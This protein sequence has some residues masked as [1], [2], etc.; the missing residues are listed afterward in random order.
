MQAD[1]LSAEPQGKPKHTEVD[2]LSFFQQI[3][4]TQELNL[5]SPALQVDSL[6]TE[7][8]EGGEILKDCLLYTI[9]LE[10]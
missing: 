10:N 1:S 4:Q 2:S 7:V 5:G 8:S 9:N 6:P 3:F